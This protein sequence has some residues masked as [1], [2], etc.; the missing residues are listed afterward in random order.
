MDRYCPMASR[1]LASLGMFS[2]SGSS[3]SGKGWWRYSK[4]SRPS[5]G[6][7]SAGRSRTSLIGMPSTSSNYTL[8]LSPS[9]S[10]N[11]SV[12]IS[13]G[14][15]SFHRG[16][17]ARWFKDAWSVPLFGVAA[18]AMLALRANNE[19]RRRDEACQDG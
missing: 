17:L 9:P 6:F 1:L 10:G 4:P 7:A 12:H 19:A 16:I 11:F 15:S 14:F 5:V 18:V 8:V 3:M 13:H 2:T